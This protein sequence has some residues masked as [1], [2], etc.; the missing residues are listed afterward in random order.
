MDQRF[1]LLASAVLVMGCNDRLAVN[2]RLRQN[3]SS[4]AIRR[5]GCAE[6]LD[7]R[8]IKPFPFEPAPWES[9]AR[10]TRGG[11][12]SLLSGGAGRVL[13]PTGNDTSTE[14]LEPYW[15]FGAL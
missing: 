13:V 6:M 10:V 3:A 12:A 9:P 11:F 15:N 2:R 4:P 1:E 14:N 7:W 8:W 5:D